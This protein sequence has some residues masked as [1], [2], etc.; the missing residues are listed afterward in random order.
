MG[1]LETAVTD[2]TTNV[3]L[4]AAWWDPVTIRRTARRLG[5]HTDASHRF[6]RGTD[7]DAIPG[8]LNLAARLLVE[9]AGG[10]VAPG[11]LDAHGNHVPRPPDGLASFAPAP[12]LG[13]RAA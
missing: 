10:T 8:A 4:E 13:R 1:G 3:L 9:A 11:F 2:K 12:A 7:L 5:M 6:E